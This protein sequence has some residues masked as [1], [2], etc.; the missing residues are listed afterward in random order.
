LQIVTKGYL[1]ESQ[2]MS[3]S[4]GHLL[5]RTLMGAAAGLA[6]TFAIQALRTA[7]QKYA[8]ST[9]PPMRGDAG[10]HVVKQIER[11]LPQNLRNRI[12]K[13]AEAITGKSLAMGYGVFFGAIYALLHGRPRTIVGEG[14]ALGLLCWAAGYLGWLPSMGITSPPWKH[15]PA[16]AIAPPIRH[17][18]YGVAT[19]AAYEGLAELVEAVR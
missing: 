3:A 14:T 9:M 2:T 13:K 7:S 16:A 15:R 11:A 8:P 17:A 6:G 10:E 1:Q 19:V 18:I 12:P 5:N 4:N